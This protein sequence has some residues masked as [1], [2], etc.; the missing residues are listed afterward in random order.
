MQTEQMEPRPRVFLLKYGSPSWAI[1]RATFATNFFAS[2]GYEIIESAEI[3]SIKDGVDIALEINPEVVVLCSSN[4]EYVRMPPDV[5]T[6]LV[7]QS[8]VI[9]A[10]DP[11]EIGE[12]LQKL[13][14]S[15]Y[16]HRK[17]PLM[18]T[19]QVIN[20]IVLK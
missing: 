11:K 5:L 13:G 18:K 12:H 8:L 20:S 2:G 16:I 4:E 15:H 10:G 3:Y 19:L 7:Q 9:V 17:S 1:A 14:I 6:L